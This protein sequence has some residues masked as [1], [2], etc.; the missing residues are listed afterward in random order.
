MLMMVV[1]FPGFLLGFGFHFD[2]WDLGQSASIADL[3]N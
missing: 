2:I 3:E 1:L